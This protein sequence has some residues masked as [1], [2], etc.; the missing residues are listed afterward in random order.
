MY[1]Q[2]RLTHSLEKL[3]LL[4]VHVLYPKSLNFLVAPRT[5]VST[6]GYFNIL[7]YCRL[8]FS[9]CDDRHYS[10]KAYGCASSVPLAEDE[11]FRGEDFI[12]KKRSRHATL[13]KLTVFRNTPSLNFV[14]VTESLYKLARMEDAWATSLLIL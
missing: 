13:A 6:F 14:I 7:R 2:C 11:L 5:T 12:R 4:S 1:E 3:V 10:K 8:D 9:L